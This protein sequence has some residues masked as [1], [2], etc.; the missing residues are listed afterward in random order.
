MSCYII[1]VGRWVEEEKAVRMSYCMLGVGW[2]GEWVSLLSL[3]LSLLYS[4]VGGMGG[5]VG[6]WD[7]PFFFLFLFWFLLVEEG[8]GSFVLPSWYGLWVG[9]WVGGWVV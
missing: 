6:G 4:T 3:S 7:V 2:V 9:G 1:W 8:E 5:W